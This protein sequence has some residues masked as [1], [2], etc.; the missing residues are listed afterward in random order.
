MEIKQ[1][2][3][4]NITEMKTDFKEEKTIFDIHRASKNQIP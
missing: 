3:Q 2:N 4:K 1:T